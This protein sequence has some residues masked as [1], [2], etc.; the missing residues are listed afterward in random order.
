VWE[1]L[2]QDQDQELLHSCPRHAQALFP[3][4]QSSCNRP[5]SQTFQLQ[6]WHSG[7]FLDE[8]QDSISL[9]I[10]VHVSVYVCLCTCVPTPMHQYAHK[11]GCTQAIYVSFLEIAI[12]LVVF[13]TKVDCPTLQW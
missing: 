5:S 3:Q 9:H 6:A 11:S 12:K 2:L 7:P 10:C 13:K 8:G 4:K 1:V